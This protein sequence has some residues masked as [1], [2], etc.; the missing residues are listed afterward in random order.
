[1]VDL[2]IRA[3]P[4]HIRST[5][6]FDADT[7][8]EATALA[9]EHFVWQ[10]DRLRVDERPDWPSIAPEDVVVDRCTMID[11]NTLPNPSIAWWV[12]G[13]EQLDMTYDHPG[14]DLSDDNLARWHQL[15]GD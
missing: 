5:Q 11:P 12:D 9:I 13:E 6:I 14:T 15:R 2:R 10:I 4:Y 3:A 7:H 1:M 8:D